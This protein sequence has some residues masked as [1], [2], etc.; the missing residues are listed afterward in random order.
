MFEQAFGYMRFL[1]V[2]FLKTHATPA[3]IGNQKDSLLDDDI[4]KFLD[5]AQKYT[6]K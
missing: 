1:F 2:T 5:R 6:N 4:A 3:A